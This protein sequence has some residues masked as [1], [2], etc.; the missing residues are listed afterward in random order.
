M[1]FLLLEP[2]ELTENIRAHRRENENSRRKI[3]FDPL[4]FEEQN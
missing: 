3:I 2:H 1:S 4:N